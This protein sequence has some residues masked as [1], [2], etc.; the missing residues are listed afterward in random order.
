MGLNSKKFVGYCVTHAGLN[1]DY[2]PICGG[3]Y[4]GRPGEGTTHKLS[5][6][7]K[8]ANK[9]FAL[10][11]ASRYEGARVVRVVRSEKIKMYKRRIR[12]ATNIALEYGPFDGAHHKMWVIDQ[13]LRAIL[14]PDYSDTLLE[15]TEDWDFGIAP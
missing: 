8:W 13:M 4:E 3:P 2:I 14:G 1:V 11:E 9:D 6:A 10:R 5:L 12:K 15:K 7:Q